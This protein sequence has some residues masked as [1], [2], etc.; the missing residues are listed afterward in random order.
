MREEQRRLL[1]GG[2]DRDLG[3]EVVVDGQEV[4]VDGREVVTDDV[5]EQ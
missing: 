2:Q 4:V 3:Q 1:A 5:G